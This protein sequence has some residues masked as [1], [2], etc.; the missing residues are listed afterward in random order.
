[1]TMVGLAG[2]EPTTSCPPD[3]RANQAA[4]QPVR[5]ESL[6]EKVDNP[7]RKIKNQATEQKFEMPRRFG[8]VVGL[9]FGKGLQVEV[10][11]RD[12]AMCVGDVGLAP[13]YG[14]GTICR[15]GRRR[16][17]LGALLAPGHV[18]SALR[19]TRSLM[20]VDPNLNDS[21]IERSRYRRYGPGNSRFTKSVKVGG[22]DAPCSA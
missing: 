2:F 1:M 14:A 18:Y 11:R 19:R 3:K 5:L 17:I 16:E 10:L 20:G 4:L 8:V 21:R 9:P 15:H 6:R 13:A 12:S 7:P 22:S